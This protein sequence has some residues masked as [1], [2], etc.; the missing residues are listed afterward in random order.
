MDGIVSLAQLAALMLPRCA[1]LS[2]AESQNELLSLILKQR[3]AQGDET[4]DMAS[5]TDHALLEESEDEE[6]RKPCVQTCCRAGQHRCLIGM[7]AFSWRRLLWSPACVVPSLV[8]PCGILGQCVHAWL[9]QG[10]DQGN[11]R[12]HAH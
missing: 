11:R 2:D 8:V 12:S 7:H 1:G 3:E 10:R 9:A 6:V 5:P 4:S